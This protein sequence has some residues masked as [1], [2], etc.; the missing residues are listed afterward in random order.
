MSPCSVRVLLVITPQTQ[1]F[2]SHAHHAIREETGSP[3]DARRA[4]SRVTFPAP[5]LR[6]DHP[7]HRGAN[8]FPGGPQPRT[9]RST[10]RRT[11]LQVPAADET[12]SLAHAPRRSVESAR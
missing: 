5:I 4:P 11:D 2:A 9:A 1:V 8:T 6:P 3:S 12:R 10:S 7:R